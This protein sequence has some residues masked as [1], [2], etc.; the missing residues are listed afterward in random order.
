[1]AWFVYILRCKRDDSLYCGISKNVD[2]RIKLHNIGKGSKYVASRL[3]AVLVYSEPST[4]RS[5][6]SKR[7]Y[8][9]KQL[10]REKKEQLICK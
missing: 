5:T 4:S 3:P 6:A 2:T 1:M 9:I 10:T 7:E 8:Q